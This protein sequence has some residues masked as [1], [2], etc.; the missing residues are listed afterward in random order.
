[1]ERKLSRLLLF[2]IGYVL[3]AAWTWRDIQQRPAKQIRGS[4][5]L[6]RVFSAINTVGAVAYWLIGRRYGG[7]AR[8]DHFP[9]VFLVTAK[10]PRQRLTPGAHD[11]LWKVGTPAQA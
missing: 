10:S 7:L 11:Q 6:W 2:L 5:G 8:A 9:S 1:M 3:A 4:K